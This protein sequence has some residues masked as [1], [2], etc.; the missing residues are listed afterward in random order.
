MDEINFDEAKQ[1]QLPLVE[2]L[3]NLGYR[4]ISRKDILVE[5]N[6]NTSKFILRETARRKFMEINQYE[7]NGQNYKFSEKDIAEV[8]DELENIPFEGLIDTSKTIYSMIMPKTGGKT[9]KVFQGGTTVSKSFKYIDFENIENNDFAVAVEFEATGKCNIRVDIVIFVNGIPFAIIENK[10]S[11][12]SVETAISQL[13]RNQQPS[14][15]PKLFIYPQLLIGTN[16]EEFKYGTTGTPNKFYAKWKEREI[17]EDEWKNRDNFNAQYEQQVREIIAKPIEPELYKQ[18]L[19]DLNGWT[20]QHTQKLDRKP[21]QQDLAVVGILRKDRLLDI[22]KNFTLYDAGIKKVMRYQQFFAIKKMLM[23]ISEKETSETGERRKGGILWQTQGSGKSLTMVMFVKALIESTEIN[24]P[25]I[26]I[27]T[28]RKDL[29]RQIKNT[30]AGAGL[31]KDVK[32]AASGEELLTLIKE[33]DLRVITTL[34][35]KFQSARNKM[36]NIDDR[37]QN[38]FVLIDEAHRTQG[39]EANMQM[40]RVIPNACYLAFTGTPLLKKDKSRQQFGPFIDKY[41]IDDA[42]EDEIILPLIYEGRYVN[43]IQDKEEID[44]Q[45]ERLSEG[46]KLSDKAKLQYEVKT[47]IIHQNPQR[48]EE[49]AYNIHR[50]YSEKFKGSGLKAQI[51]APSKYAATL[52]QKFFGAKGDITTALVISDEDGNIQA[53]DEHKQEVVDYIEKIKANYKSLLSYEKEVIESF[54]HNEEGIEI[55]IVVD[56]LLTGFDAPRNTVLYLAK[57]LKDHNLLQAIARVNRLY[58]ND[59]LPKTAGYIIDYS[60]NAANLKTAMQLFGNFDEED[61]KGTLIDVDKKIKELEN[62]YA[63]LHDKFNGIPK[64]DQAYIEYLQDEATRKEFSEL[65]NKFI[66][67]FKDCIILRDFVNKFELIDTYRKDLKKFMYLR[68]T[69]DLKNQDSEDFSRHKYT[70]YKIIDKNI[71][72]EE[73]ELL[74]SQININNKELFEKALEHVKTDTSKAETIA[75]QVNKTINEKMESDPEFYDRF[76]KK[77]SKIIEEMRLKKLADIEALKQIR[78]IEDQVLSK[79]DN[80]APSK[81][82]TIPGADIFY[83]NLKDEFENYNIPDDT[84][85]DITVDI[86]KTI[87]DK[88]TVDWY[89]NTE[90]VRIMTNAIDDLLYDEVKVKRGINLT[91]E[92]RKKI[93]TKTVELARNN[94]DIL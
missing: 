93:M 7:H 79:K 45:I 37:D 31:K 67:T 22:S 52:I 44:K 42:L 62:Q 92:D 71:K 61:V 26:I 24:N 68:M 53:E 11:S 18:I 29:D 14:H 58:D 75:S 70:L 32:Q 83:R 91:N 6:G 81:I 20:Y 73:A 59:L 36:T 15:C 90:R 60:E 69:V 82:A 48:I 86:L 56:K 33:K 4:Y 12:E 80:T 34:V 57:Q 46:W 27:V 49:I 21:A 2:M 17:A 1:S 43:L 66:N 9:I 40:N 63:A 84:Y 78:L 38:I 65:L 77:I 87:E 10:K 72:A 55:L 41:T 76:S 19:E 13:N 23:R 54:K 28:D 3:V 94:Y 16:K 50:H 85:I 5:R 89:L 88:S 74:T 64:D 51:V 47:K 35:H 8:I 39:G 25:R 30:F